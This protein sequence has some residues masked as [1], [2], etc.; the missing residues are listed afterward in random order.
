MTASGQAVPNAPSP[1][2][3]WLDTLRGLAV[4]AMTVFHFTWDLE[5]FHYAP[6]GLTAEPGWRWF[7]R[8]IATSFLLLAG[9]SFVLAHRN[10]LRLR[11]FLIRF[12]QIAAA[13]AAISL[14]TYFATPD[15]FVFFGILHQI[16]A[17]SL[18][19]ALLLPLPWFAVASLGATILA[20]NATWASE[21]FTNPALWW[22]GLAPVDPPTNDYVP[23]FPWSAWVLFG[24]AF[25]KLYR[26]RAVQTVAT[27]EPVAK[28]LRGLQFVGRNSLIY[29]LV[30]QPVMIGL[31]AAFAWLVPPPAPDL[32]AN[33]NRACVTGCSPTRD[34]AFCGRFCRCVAEDLMAKSIFDSVATGE[35]GVDDT[36]VAD[37]AQVCTTKADTGNGE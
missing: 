2:Y 34:E 22:V 36:R 32:A 15:R 26:G 31:V 35:L 19:A 10:G 4:V 1:R 7:A 28:P 27:V 6:A 29:Y 23:V 37:A 20:I 33:F 13:S 14:A 3:G 24:M 12:A 9:F 18:I 30:H 25:A 8:V 11:P 16:A 17:A 21:I 5:F